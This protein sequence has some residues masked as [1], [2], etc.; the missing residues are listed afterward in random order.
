MRPQTIL[1]LA[2]TAAAPPVLALAHPKP[3]PNPNPPIS[4]TTLVTD[5]Y[6]NSLACAAKN[7]AINT[8]IDALCGSVSAHLTAGAS[9]HTADGAWALSISN[10]GCPSDSVYVPWEYCMAQFHYVCAMGGAQGGGTRFWGTG[11]CQ[12][13]TIARA[14]TN[15]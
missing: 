15:D 7:A 6:A 13:W 11:G 4:S 5:D 9:A 8:A 2:T 1:I 14:V 3:N 12:E 10:H